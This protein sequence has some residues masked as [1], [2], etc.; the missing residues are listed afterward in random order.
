MKYSKSII[1]FMLLNL[2]IVFLTV[3]VGNK[4]REI[5]KNNNLLKNK[6]LAIK[7]EI[8]IN[9]IEFTTHKNANYLGKLYSIYF[10]NID[11]HGENPNL[12]TLN[13]LLLRNNNYKLV[14]SKN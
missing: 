11:Y 2:I 8:H 10:T 1:A 12:V 14:N 9:L 7:E 4:T 5:E 13:E 3:Y 6:I